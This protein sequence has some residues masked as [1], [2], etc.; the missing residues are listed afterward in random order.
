AG[1]SPPRNSKTM[2]ISGSSTTSST[3]SV[4]TP[5]GKSMSR[6]FSSERT[7][8][9]LTAKRSPVLCAISC[10][11]PFKSRHTPPPT[12]PQPRKPM[13]MVLSMSPTSFP[14]SAV[15][16]IDQAQPLEGEDAVELVD[17]AVLLGHQAGHAARGDD[18]RVRRA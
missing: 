18:Q 3:R 2:E 4:S 17:G 14:A 8:T 9:R 7:S 10:E 13:V 12:L 5:G 11:K 15:A 6:F 16:F 1:S